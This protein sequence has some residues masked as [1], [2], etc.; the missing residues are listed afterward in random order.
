M[1]EA[2]EDFL[3]DIDE[4]IINARAKMQKAVAANPRTASKY[5]KSCIPQYSINDG[6]IQALKQVKE[7][8]IMILAK[9]D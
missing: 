2:I 7:Q 8:L 3:D 6:C 4:S 5:G 9:E 1:R